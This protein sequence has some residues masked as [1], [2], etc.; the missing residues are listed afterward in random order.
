MTM[1]EVLTL[2]IGNLGITL[3]QL[4]LLITALGSLIFMALDLRLGLMM[5]FFMFGIETVA[6]WA[7][8]VASYDLYLAIS[9][10]L[11]SFVLMALSLL[12]SKPK[13]YYGGIL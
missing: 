2:L 11:A 12:M 7:A 8:A 4:V 5:L 1:A 6:F 3:P 9:A 13:D 10:L